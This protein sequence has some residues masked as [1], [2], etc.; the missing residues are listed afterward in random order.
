VAHYYTADLHLGHANI[1]DMCN[2]PFASVEE[3]DEALIDNIR[4]VVTQKDDLWIVGDLAMVKAA[5]KERVAQL[6]KRIPGRKHLIA[7]NHDRPWVKELKWTSVENLIEIKDEGRR[8]TLCHYP[9][10]TWPGSRHGALQ[11]FGHVH[12]N[13]A[14]CRGCVN[15][16]VDLWDYRPVTLEEVQAR[17]D[18]LPRNL[19]WDQLE[20]GAD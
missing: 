13:W 1:I 17:S 8:V 14:G 7:G 19:Y 16:G 11:L 2:R 18:T 6:F 5:G 9:L 4:R 20:P 10:M 3:M 12:D 15:V